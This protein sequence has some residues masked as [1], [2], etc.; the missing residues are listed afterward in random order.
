MSDGER[1]FVSTK[2]AA[3]ILDVSVDTVR[4]YIKQKK[5]R[6]R[7]LGD[8]DKPRKKSGARQHRIPMVDI[9]KLLDPV[10]QY[11]AKKEPTT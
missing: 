4:E 8:D 11:E 6:S 5:L 2:E 1:E 9:R 3:R 10:K 7:Q